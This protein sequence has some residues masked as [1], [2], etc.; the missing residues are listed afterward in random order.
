MV[1]V[2]GFSFGKGVTT[3]NDHIKV[4]TLLPKMGGAPPKSCLGGG[5]G[6]ILGGDL[7]GGFGRILLYCSLS[8][9]YF[10]LRGKLYIN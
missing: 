4:A 5:L 6:G 3:D 1:K 8:T 7:G 2:K 10:V 9:K